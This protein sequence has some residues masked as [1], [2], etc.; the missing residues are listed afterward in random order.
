MQHWL[1]WLLRTFKVKKGLPDV[2]KQFLRQNRAKTVES[3]ESMEKKLSWR[4]VWGL[5]TG[6]IG[7]MPGAIYAVLSFT[8]NLSK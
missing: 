2:Q 1:Y 5:E 8:Q 4:E 3:L 6:R 7:F